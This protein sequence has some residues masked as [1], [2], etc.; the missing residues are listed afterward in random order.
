[1]GNDQ[2]GREQDEV[3]EQAIGTSMAAAHGYNM[4]KAGFQILV[5]R[6]TA[7]KRVEELSHA[8]K[9]GHRDPA[10]TQPGEGLF[11]RGRQA[12]GEPELRRKVRADIGGAI[13]VGGGAELS[14]NAKPPYS[15][16]SQT[17]SA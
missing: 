7:G 2:R 1:M 16:R 12:L 6:R 9:P 3:T 5:K 11:L 13:A 8:A 10:V 4:S 15:E 17:R 14:R